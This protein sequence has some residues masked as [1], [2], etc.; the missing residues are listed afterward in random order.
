M[1]GDPYPHS[2]SASS[3]GCKRNQETEYQ[4]VLGGKYRTLSATIGLNDDT[5]EEP[6]V[7]IEVEVDG[8]TKFSEDMQAGDRQPA[9]ISIRG[10]QRLTLRQIYLG[11]R[12]NFCSE[13]ATAVWGDA[14]VTT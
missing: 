1:K 3:G 5:T 11:P 13:N 14:R 2:V 12:R 6:R 8:E 7:R 10:A 9:N 4:W